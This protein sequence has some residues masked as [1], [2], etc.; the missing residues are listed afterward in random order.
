M[1]DQAFAIRVDS[2]EHPTSY[3]VLNSLSILDPT[4][5]PNAILYHHPI[6]WSWIIVGEVV[7]TS[8]PD[9]TYGGHPSSIA[10]TLVDSK[11]R[12]KQVF[13]WRKLPPSEAAEAIA[14]VGE[15][16][17]RAGTFDI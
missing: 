17:S 12:F 11:S 6:D 4:N 10:I 3:V 16:F 2:L 13:F 14:V 8:Q 5:P 15:H 1:R 9:I 7:Y